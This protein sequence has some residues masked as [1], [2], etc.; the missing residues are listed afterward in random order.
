MTRIDEGITQARPVQALQ[1][2]PGELVRVRSAAG[3]FSTL[4]EQGSLDGMPFMPE[5]LK[6]SGRVLPVYKRADKT[7]D[8]W[9]V[10]RMKNTVHLSNIRCD[11]ASHGGCQA[12]CLMHWKEAWLERA[13]HAG[14]N[15]SLEGDPQG[16]DNDLSTA[17][18]AF[19]T[20]T[21]VPATIKH[22]TGNEHELTYR[23]QATE[24]PSAST[25]VEPRHLTQYP[26][27]VRNWGLRKVLRGW[28]VYVFNMFQKANRELLPRHTL[29]Q[30]GLDY[31][32]LA[33]TAESGNTP[34]AR[35]DLK[36]GDWVRIKSKDEIVKTLDPANKNRGLSFDFEMVPYCGGAARVLARVERLVDEHTGKMIEI[37]SD[38]LILEGVVC[39]ADY[40]RFCTRSTYHYW[41]EIWLEKIT[42]DA[43]RSL[44][45]CGPGCTSA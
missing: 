34:S 20:D 3:I 39:K 23:C 18:R 2:K 25:R 37:K 42:A 27:D 29:I 28:V 8:G 36:P 24:I 10:R 30:G 9:S 13:E 26:R 12:A 41:R 14:L 17:E 6:Y 19:V 45:N 4:D 1:L 43:P 31:P 7:C 16:K 22:D 44:T 21:L 33:G 38:C 32:F 35:L 15:G 40:H 11:G 5:M